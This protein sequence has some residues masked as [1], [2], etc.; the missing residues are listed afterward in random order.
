[1]V[2]ERYSN[3]VFFAGVRRTGEQPV[4][5]EGVFYAGRARPAAEP[6]FLDRATATP[7]RFALVLFLAG[8]VG[9]LFQ[10]SLFQQI[11]FGAPVFEEI[12][13]FGPALLVAT[14]LRARTAWVR[15]PLAWIFG[16]AFGVIEHFV[17]YVEEPMWIYA[18]RVV[19]HAASTGLSMLVYGALDPLPDARARWGSTVPST[20]LHWAFNFGGIVLGLGSAFL[21]IGDAVS[22]GYA[23]LVSG[24]IVAATLWA[25]VDRAGFEARVRTIFERAV[26]RLGWKSS[27]APSTAMR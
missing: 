24:A 2:R 18:E 16:G 20:L 14:L 25:L 9:I 3:D 21:P 19:F 10:R 1:M 6:G 26:P 5:P 17:T 4:V 13:K 8:W 22:G 23:V 15:L 11:V 7:L 12:A 27:T